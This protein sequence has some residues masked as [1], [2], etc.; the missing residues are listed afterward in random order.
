MIGKGIK[1]R[2]IEV[3]IQMIQL[4]IISM[5]DCL[6]GKKDRLLLNVRKGEKI[7]VQSEVVNCHIS[8]LHYKKI[9]FPGQYSLFPSINLTPFLKTVVF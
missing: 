7:L 2:G 6:Q 3:H 5:A 1:S 8:R 9:L 4:K